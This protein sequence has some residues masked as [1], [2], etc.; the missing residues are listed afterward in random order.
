MKKYVFLCALF[1]FVI[2]AVLGFQSHYEPIEEDSREKNNALS[3][4]ESIPVT[5]HDVVMKKDGLIIYQ[6][7]YTK[8]AYTKEQAEVIPD[9]LEGLNREQLQGIYNGWQVV[10]FSPEKVI[11]RSSIEGRSDEVYYIGVY[12]GYVSI[13]NEDEGRNL[14][15]RDKTEIPLKVLPEIEQMQIKEGI[16]VIGEENL[17]KLLA[18]YSS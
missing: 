9:F 3:I 17:V 16:C 5:F 6:Y 7:Y 8:D 18:D 15:L 11:L 4:R 13:F 1:C 12:D 2:S 10:Y 14:K